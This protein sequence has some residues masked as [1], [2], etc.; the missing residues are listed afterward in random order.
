M[1]LPSPR[2]WSS[3]MGLKPIHHHSWLQPTGRRRRAQCFK[4]QALSLLVSCR[5]KPSRI[6]TPHP[7]RL[8]NAWL[9][10]VCPGQSVMAGAEEGVS[11]DSYRP[12]PPRGWG[13][14]ENKGF[15]QDAPGSKSQMQASSPGRGLLGAVYSLPLWS[16]SSCRPESRRKAGTDRHKGQ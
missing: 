10:S 11:V 2:A 1:A 4:P 16:F 6:S 14:K 5:W 12:P 3:A 9:G 15:V 13:S 8:R 7:G